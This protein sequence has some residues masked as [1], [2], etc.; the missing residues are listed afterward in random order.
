MIISHMKNVVF[1]LGLILWSLVSHAQTSLTK[2]TWYNQEKESKIQFFMQDGLLYGKIV[3]LKNGDVVDKKNPDPALK[4]K[5]LLG[6]VILKGFKDDGAKS[7]KDGKIYDPRSGKTYDAKI[8]LK[9]A[10]V[11]EIR[12]FIGSPVF[13]KTTSF[14]RA[15]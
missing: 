8:S 10:T 9:S 15:E 5:S 6:N 3:W 7:W 12:G 14:T 11:L 1:S 4:N 2:G 13:G